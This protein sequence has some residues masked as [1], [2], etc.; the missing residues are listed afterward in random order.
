M[1][2]IFGFGKQIYL[3]RIFITVGST[4]CKEKIVGTF[5]NELETTK[6][7]FQRVNSCLYN[8]FW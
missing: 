3:K 7:D 6:M 4:N 1:N 2:N 5:T 8:F